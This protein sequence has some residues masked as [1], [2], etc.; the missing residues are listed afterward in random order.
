MKFPGDTWAPEIFGVQKRSAG[1]FVEVHIARESISWS[2]KRSLLCAR[3]TWI[4]VLHLDRRAVWSRPGPVVLT[5]NL[6]RPI[7]SATCIIRI[8]YPRID[9][10]NQRNYK[11]PRLEI[12]SPH[13][14]NC[15][16]AIAHHPLYRWASTPRCDYHLRNTRMAHHHEPAL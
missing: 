16:A 15:S 13:A 12:L 8:G 3:G 14:R 4:L 2:R 10:M 6:L 11:L 9:W 5:C 7:S 1:K